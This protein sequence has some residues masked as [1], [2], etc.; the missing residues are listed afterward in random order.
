MLP[1]DLLDQ[2][3]NVSIS[4]IWS[5]DLYAPGDKP[6]AAMRWVQRA[7]LYLALD[8]QEDG[9]LD[10]LSAP[11]ISDFVTN[12]RNRQVDVTVALDTSYASDA[13]LAG[14]QAKVGDSAIWSMET[15]GEGETDPVPQ[16]VALTPLLPNHGGFAAFYASVGDSHARELGFDDPNG[17]RTVYGAFSFRLANVIQNRDSV[18]VR[19]LAES[20]K[21]LPVAE[22]FGEQR[23]RIEATDPELA[24]FTD[25]SRAEPQ[26][27]PIVITNPA[28][29]RGAAVM[30]RPE[31]DIEGA[32]NWSA[33]TKAVLVDGKIA[34][35][36]P[37]KTFRY[38]QRKTGINSLRSWR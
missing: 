8:Q 31:V 13:D 3:S 25:L 2:Y 38:R 22:G 7:G 32:V 1:Q 14:S 10:V 34:E 18:T 37:D 36:R 33:P 29:K 9:V 30:E 19:A 21:T 6:T 12:L 5:A 16:Y 20:L 28:P 24:M 23:Y 27:E 4:D 26:T 15:G 11:D 17:N 35:L